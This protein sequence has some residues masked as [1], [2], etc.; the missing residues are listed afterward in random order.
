MLCHVNQMCLSVLYIVWHFRSF[1]KLFCLIYQE[2]TWEQWEGQ[3]SNT[4]CFRDEGNYKM[5]GIFGAQT[6]LLYYTQL[7]IQSIRLDQTFQKWIVSMETKYIYTI[8]YQLGSQDCGSHDSLLLH[9]FSLRSQKWVKVA[10]SSLRRLK[11]SKP[12]NSQQ[13]VEFTEEK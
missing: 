2:H 4:S 1:K 7:L 13:Q 6:P 11:R 5:R 3:K 8:F 12:T 9:T 10:R